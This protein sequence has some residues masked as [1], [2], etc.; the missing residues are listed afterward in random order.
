MRRVAV[1]LSL[2][3]TT[4]RDAETVVVTGTRTPERVSR[5]TVKTDVVTREEAERRGAANVVDALASQPGLQVNPGSY[6]YLGGVSALQIQGFDRD[7]VLILE[8]GERVVG[9][10]GGA[11]DLAAREL[12]LRSQVYVG[13]LNVLDTKQELGRLGDTRPPLGRILYVGLRGELPWED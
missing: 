11:V 13:A 12:R 1:P 6:G 3:A 10:V 8:D 2:V 7:R 4:G 5:M 9:D